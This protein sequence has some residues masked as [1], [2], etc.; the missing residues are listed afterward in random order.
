MRFGA[1]SLFSRLVPHSECDTTRLFQLAHWP[2]VPLPSAFLP[3][4]PDYPVDPVLTCVTWLTCTLI[5]VDLVNAPPVVTGLA[6]TVIQIHLTVKACQTTKVGGSML[7][8][9]AELHTYA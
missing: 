6:L 8:T 7:L 1:A 4:A 5:A 3:P 9:L 2:P